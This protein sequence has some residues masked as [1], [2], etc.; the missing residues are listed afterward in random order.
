[1]PVKIAKAEFTQDI[2]I[3]GLMRRRPLSLDVEIDTAVEMTISEPGYP[4]T[5]LVIKVG[6]KVTRLVPESHYVGLEP[7][8]EKAITPPAKVK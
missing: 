2:H 5:M 7:L 3:P 4:D 8:F 1:M 6:G